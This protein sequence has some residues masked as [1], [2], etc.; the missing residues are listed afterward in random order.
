MQNT[1][2]YN[3][4]NEYKVSNFAQPIKTAVITR[5]YNI[6]NINI[7]KACSD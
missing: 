7:Y 2:L 1:Y 4:Q 5:K 3:N 6:N